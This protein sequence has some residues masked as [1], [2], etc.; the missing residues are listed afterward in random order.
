MIAFD[1]VASLPFVQVRTIYV[2][3]IGNTEMLKIGSTRDIDSRLRSLSTRYKAD[4]HLVALRRGTWAD[5]S[6]IL[7]AFARLA[8]SGRETFRDDGTIAAWI[9]TLPAACRGMFTR[10]YLGAAGKG[11]TARRALP[12][13]RRGG[14]RAEV[15]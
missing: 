12:T 3:R 6:R 5:E 14:F 7:R 2:V 15:C 11:P 1:D 9:E 13:V 4:L 10:I 8:V